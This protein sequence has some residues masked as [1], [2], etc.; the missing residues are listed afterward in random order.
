MALSIPRDSDRI[1]S[2]R[3]G[4]K[5][6]PPPEDLLCA[7]VTHQVPLSY[8]RVNGSKLAFRFKTQRN[9][10]VRFSQLGIVAHTVNP[11]TRES[12]AGGSL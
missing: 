5:E 11:S 12:E 3:G 4:F 10:E 9:L 8:S 2:L 7:E 6:A 1:H